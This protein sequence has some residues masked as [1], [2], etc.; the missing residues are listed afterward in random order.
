MPDNRT[1]ELERRLAISEDEIDPLEFRLA[2]IE[3]I[4]G[5]GAFVP[6]AVVD[7]LLRGGNPVRVWREH[8]GISLR[9]LARRAGISATLLSEIERG[10]KEG[11]LPTLRAIAGALDVEFEELV[12]VETA[13]SEI[14]LE[15]S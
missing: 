5:G 9:E 6:G 10:R 15:G 12:P 8:R 7:R 11:S 14:P 13:G 3:H 2:E 4:A 1:A